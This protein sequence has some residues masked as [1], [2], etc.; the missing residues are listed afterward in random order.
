VLDH[1]SRWI[2]H[3]RYMPTPKEQ[4]VMRYYKNSEQRVQALGLGAGVLVGVTARSV[5]MLT[6]V[7]VS[8]IGAALGIYTAT[9]Y[10]G[11]NYITALVHLPHSPI[12]T[13]LEQ[14]IK[15]QHNAQ[16]LCTRYNIN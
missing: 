13:E 15:L 14:H 16:Q 7:G 10:H 11:T 5:P 4:E 12:A 6:R 2:K 3:Y 8:A 9:S 1:L